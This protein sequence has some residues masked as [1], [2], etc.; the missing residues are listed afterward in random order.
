MKRKG[1]FI[2]CKKI[3]GRLLG[4]LVFLLVSFSLSF[5]YLILGP[6]IGRCDRIPDG[7]MPAFNYDGFK[8]ITHTQ[9]VYKMDGQPTQTSSG[10]SYYWI[11]GKEQVSGVSCWKGYSSQLGFYKDTSE[12]VKTVVSYIVWVGD[13]SRL[14]GSD[15]EF[16]DGSS[17]STRFNPYLLSWKYGT[18]LG[19]QWT[20]NYR[21]TS[22]ICNGDYNDTVRTFGYETV[23]TPFGTFS[24]CLR[25]ERHTTG[26]VTCSG[27]TQYVGSKITFW[28][29]LNKGTIKYFQQGENWENTVYYDPEIVS[30]PPDPIAPTAQFTQNVTSGSAPVI[31]Y[32]TDTSTGTISSW[33]WNFGD[34][35]TST[36]QHP[37]HTYYNPGTYTVSL[38]VTGP[39]GSD[40]KTKTGYITVTQP[41]PDANFT[42]N[43]TS[44]LIPLTVN[45]VNQSTGNISSYSW[46]FGDGGTSTT[47]NPIH[48]YNTPGA[49]TVRLTVTGLGGSDTKTRSDYITATSP[50]GS[51]QVSLAPSGAIDEGALWNVDGGQW[52]NSGVTVS[53]LSVGAHIVNYKAVFGWAAPSSE[54]V[55]ITYDQTTQIAGTYAD[56]D[57]SPSVATN[58]ASDITS[59][60]ALL[61]GAVNPN[62]AE[63]TALFEYGANTNY[64]FNTS[65]ISV[66]AGASYVSVNEMISGLT[67]DATYHYR[68]VASN[69]D[70]TSYGQDRFFTTTII[71]VE[72][73]GV[74]NENTPCFST[75]Q[76]AINFA[77]TGSTIKIVE[78][79]YGEGIVLDE[80]KQLNLEGGWNATFT[81]RASDT[82]IES[83]TISAGTVTSDY[84]VIR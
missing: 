14:Y 71:Y 83:M 54:T 46:D 13:E 7:Y 60:S 8:E 9:T 37:S 34:G 56:V 59:T 82:T 26:T 16:E 48:T 5:A 33:S 12:S 66:G 81:T 51:L 22:E 36:Q 68:L 10:T 61:N 21:F 75:I 50:A 35:G 45:F 57:Y 76:D 30:S 70:G 62:G 72:P 2:M 77:S 63:T 67:P 4:H 64:G 44:G 11:D 78:G 42:A 27:H 47:Q 25:W 15:V 1:L 58:S 65:E 20:F 73:S 19:S 23:T 40:T 28:S 41:P 49:Y 6:S 29:A 24:N 31:V 84:L 43:P 32:F 38:I 39:V 80:P 79:N 52:Q 18:E 3:S 17:S 69:S 74:C 53:D 55:T